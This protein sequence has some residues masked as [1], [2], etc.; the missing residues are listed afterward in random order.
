MTLGSVL[1]AA[2]RNWT[3]L[4]FG[5]AFQGLSAAG[6]MN[7]IKI[8]LADRVTLAEQSKNSTIF[9]LLNGFSFSVGPIIGGYL[10]N[11]NWRYCFVV[12]IP[13]AVLAQIVIFTVLRPELVRGTHH[14]TGATR[15][16]VLAGLS[17]IDYGGTVLFIF[18]AGLLILGVTWGGV[19]YPW[20]SAHVMAPLVI[21]GVL[22][23]SFFI[24]EYLLEPGRLISRIFPQ[25]VA[26]IPWSLFARKDAFLLSIIN[27]ATGAALYSAFYFVGIFWTLVEAYDPGKAGTRLLYYL[28]GLG[29]GGYT[30]MFLC[31]VWPRQTFFPLSIGSIVEAAGFAVLAYAT[32]TRNATLVS[33]FM[34][35]SGAGT[36][37]RLMPNTL[38][39]A[40]VWPTKLAAVMS[41][42][43]FALPFGGTVSIAIMSAV[44]YNKFSKALTTLNVG[45]NV[46]TN[47]TSNSTSSLQSIN[48]LPTAIQDQIREKAAKAVMWSFIS[49]LPIMALSVTSAILLGNVWIKPSG[50]MDQKDARGEVIYSSYLAALF[51]V[52]DFA[53][54]SRGVTNIFKGKLKSRKVPIDSNRA[55]LEAEDQTK[56]NEANRENEPNEQHEA[57]RHEL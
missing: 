36:G 29:I 49:V 19:H 50:K 48:Q 44:F 46:A 2:A 30:A 45:Q 53:I 21:G 27:A 35:F 32:S 5:R 1:C 22:F 33:V 10:A 52:G 26:M 7:T 56:E 54:A 40:G 4:L 47:F 37:V 23:V 18:G 14:A 57:S 28:P 51:T 24:Y 6:L 34:A 31:N 38:H 12:S 17:T 20:T 9:A 11:S 25:Q 3:M 55:V 42:M 39:A 13:V 41:L 8:I 43:D 15:K 16:S